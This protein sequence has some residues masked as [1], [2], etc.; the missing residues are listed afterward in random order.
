MYMYSIYIVSVNVSPLVKQI[1]VQFTISRMTG[2]SIMS[3]SRVPPRAESRSLP[4]QG[5]FVGAEVVR[6]VDWRWKDQD[7]DLKLC[8]YVY[9]SAKSS[10]HA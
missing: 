8:M 4:A 7:G 2:V 6:G 9:G 3:S 1:N 5:L 10:M